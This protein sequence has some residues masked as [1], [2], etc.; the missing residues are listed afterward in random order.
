MQPLT[1]AGRQCANGCVPW[2]ALERHGALRRPARSF[3][4]ELL[5]LTSSNFDHLR[6]ETCSRNYSF[7][8]LRSATTR[9]TDRLWLPVLLRRT[10][11][12]RRVSADEL[13]DSSLDIICRDPAIR[14]SRRWLADHCG[15]RRHQ[16]PSNMGLQ[17]GFTNHL[18]GKGC[19]ATCSKRQARRMRPPCRHS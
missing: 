19:S 6:G 15:A 18:M 7:V 2:P 13:Q 14:C 11:S 4:A 8:S 12:S 10:S 3:H 1:K 5:L 17:H 16:I 9:T